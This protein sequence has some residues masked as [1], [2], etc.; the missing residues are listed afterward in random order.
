MDGVT[1]GN[2]AQTLDVYLIDSILMVSK[3][4]KYA[5]DK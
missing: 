1:V 2:L 5:V 3:D 4:I